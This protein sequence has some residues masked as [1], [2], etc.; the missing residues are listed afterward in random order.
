MY[1]VIHTSID[2]TSNAHKSRQLHSPSGYRSFFV[3]STPPAVKKALSGLL[4][5]PKNNTCADCKAQSHPRWA[6]WSLGVFV[7]I[8]CAG[9]HRSLGTH[10]S[11]VKSVDLDIWKEEHLVVLVKMRNNELANCFYES[12]LPDGMKKPLTDNNQLQTFIRN[13]YE[14]RKWVGTKEPLHQDND[15]LIEQD[16]LGVTGKSTPSSATAASSSNESLVT[17]SSGDVKPLLKTNTNNSLSSTSSSLLN[18]K[19][20]A[21]PKTDNSGRTGFSERPDLKKSILSLYSKPANSKTQNSF[22]AK[23]NTSASTISLPS[24]QLNMT[25]TNNGQNNCNASNDS[26]TNISVS[27]LDDNE[28]FKNVWST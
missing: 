22:F 10:I 16:Q 25:M 17:N 28:L 6:S 19:L 14:K 18:L 23:G 8:K 24:G 12:K 3:M 11:K 1:R 2:R 7:C 9:I 27:S 26:N 21:M 5:D 15:I 13:K 4:R 20:S